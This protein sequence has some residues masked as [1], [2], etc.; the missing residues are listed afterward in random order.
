MRLNSNGLDWLE[1]LIRWLHPWCV[2]TPNRSWHQAA[3]DVKTVSETKT[4]HETKVV[5]EIK[6]FLKLKA[7][8]KPNC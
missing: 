1:A 3:H 6:S 8:A 5:S 7:F 2:A 4:I